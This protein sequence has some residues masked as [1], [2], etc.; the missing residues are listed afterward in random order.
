MTDGI[1]WRFLKAKGL[2]YSEDFRTYETQL[3]LAM[4][5]DGGKR[6]VNMASSSYARRPG[7][8]V[9]EGSWSP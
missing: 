2:D 6:R 4:G 8:T 3:A 7:V 5:R 1:V 9:P